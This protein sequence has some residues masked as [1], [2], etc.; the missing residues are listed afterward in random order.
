[1][2]AVRRGWASFSAVQ[3]AG[4]LLTCSPIPASGPAT[5]DRLPLPFATQGRTRASVG[6]GHGM[7]AS[8]CDADAPRRTAS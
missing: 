5:P 3:C 8:P 1:M 6:A 7:R 4:L 2:S